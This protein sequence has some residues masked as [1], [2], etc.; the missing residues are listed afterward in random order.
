MG[1]GDNRKSL[2]MR[3]RK[4]AKRLKARIL[5]KIQGKK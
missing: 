5:A 4:A 1:K 3:R 2:K